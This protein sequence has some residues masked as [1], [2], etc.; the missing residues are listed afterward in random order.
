MSF[1]DSEIIAEGTVTI[2]EVLN[3]WGD[4]LVKQMHHSLGRENLGSS[5]LK[6]SIEYKVTTT[7]E[8]IRFTLFFEDYGTFLDEGVAGKGGGKWSVHT[9]DSRFKF[10]N[11]KPPIDA[12]RK[13]AGQ[14]GINK[15]VLQEVIYRRGIRKREWF[16]RVLDQN[17]F[18]RLS[19][20][21]EVQIAD[22]IEIN[23]AKK[24]KEKDGSAGFETIK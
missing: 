12:I 1:L 21:L 17:P 7:A 6:Q 19:T 8:G 16:K 2:E 23:I 5:Q 20:E 14:K 18:E 11:K 3:I 4:E 10:R 15:W 9:P 24:F 22:N 13:W